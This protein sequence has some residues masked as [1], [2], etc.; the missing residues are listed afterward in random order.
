MN[1]DQA[2][3]TPP[4]RGRPAPRGSPPLIRAVRVSD[5]EAINAMASLPGFRAGTL[6]LPFQSP[7]QTRKWLE[8]RSADDLGI[9]AIV[10]DVLVGSAGF[11]RHAGRRSHAAVVGIGIHDDHVGRGIGTAMFDALIDAADNWLGLKRLEL[12]VYSDNARAIGLYEKFGFEVEG[13]LKAYAFRAGRYADVLAM[14]RLR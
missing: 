12:T 4:V 7:E 14:A 13:T 9:V 1:Q 5:F 3:E 8:N 11:T 10:D 6:R 2:T